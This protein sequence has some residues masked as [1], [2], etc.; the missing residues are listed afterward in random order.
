MKKKNYKI[1]NKQN[2]LLK[3]KVIGHLIIG[4]RKKKSEKVLLKSIKSLQ[5]QSLK[6]YK[7]IINLAVMNA[8][9]I[10]KVSERRL[11]KTKKKKKLLVPFFLSNNCIRI[12]TALKNIINN[13]R[14]I[15]SNLPFYNNLNKEL[16]LNAKKK[17]EN[18]KI[19]N[20][21]QRLAIEKKKF[22]DNYKWRNKKK[23]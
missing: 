22:L 19:K 15:S 11:K 3:Q 2:T 21:T 20:D 8:I 16:V 13:T 18:I 7:E 10:F 1:I 23:T 5:K 6:S 12:S 17:C 14:K 9:P 4:G